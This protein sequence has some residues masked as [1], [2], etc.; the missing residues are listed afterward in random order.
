M[1][2]GPGNAWVDWCAVSVDQR[3]FRGGRTV[4]HLPFVLQYV[5]TGIPTGDIDSPSVVTVFA[6]SAM[7][8][9]GSMNL[10]GGGGT[11]KAISLGA[12]ASRISKTRTPATLETYPAGFVQIVWADDSEAAEVPLLGVGKMKLAQD[13]LEPAN[14][15]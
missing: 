2:S 1:M 8:G 14:Q 4:L 12:N 15:R 5:P 7:F 13:V 10:L 11:Q 9:R 6:A 3:T